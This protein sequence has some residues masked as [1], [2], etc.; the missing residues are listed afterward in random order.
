MRPGA[1]LF[2]LDGTIY[3]GKTVIPGSLEALLFLKNAAIPYRFI[4]NNTRMTKKD[5]VLMLK[6]MNLPVS[7]DDV[8]AAPHAAAIHCKNMGYKK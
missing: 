2:D 1:L 6:N 5:L 8:F 7:T 4:T 3:K